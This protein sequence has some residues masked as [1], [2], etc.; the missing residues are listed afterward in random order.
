MSSIFRVSEGVSLLQRVFFPVGWHRLNEQRENIYILPV[1][2]T[3]EYLYEGH[4]DV[5]EGPLWDADACTHCLMMHEHFKAN[6]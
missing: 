5:K 1:G 6:V 2:N 3:Y 4:L